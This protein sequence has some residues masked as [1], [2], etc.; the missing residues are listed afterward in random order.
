MKRDQKGYVTR[1]V[2]EKTGTTFF[3]NTETGEVQLEWP[4]ATPP[5]SEPPQPP[6]VEKG[7]MEGGRK[8]CTKN[9]FRGEDRARYF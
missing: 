7:S 9:G 5:G 6:A 4:G 1:H 2:D 3:E 8:V